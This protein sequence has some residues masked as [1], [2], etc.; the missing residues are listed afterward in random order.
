MLA[1]RIQP[2]KSRAGPRI[3]DSGT[4]YKGQTRY[5]IG[6][7]GDVKQRRSQADARRDVQNCAS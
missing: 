2:A 1:G 6:K 7:G 3:A 5:T 4:L